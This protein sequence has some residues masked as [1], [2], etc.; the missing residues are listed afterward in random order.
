METNQTI[1][2]SS[3]LGRAAASE[4]RMGA[5]GGAERKIADKVIESPL[6]VTGSLAKAR[7]QFMNT[8][9]A[10][11]EQVREVGQKIAL[12]GRD[13]ARRMETVVRARPLTSV[14]V[15]AGVSALA[16]YAAMRLL[17]RSERH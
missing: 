13:Y 10:E 1:T 7:E 2:G 6:A 15:V 12:R 17:G 16:V 5:V 3:G 9:Q 4:P 11:L 8:A 14:A